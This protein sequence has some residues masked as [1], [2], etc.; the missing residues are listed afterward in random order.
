MITHTGFLH[1]FLFPSMIWSMPG[2]KVFLTFDDGPHPTVTPAVL[3]AL[4]RHGVT[5]TFFLSGQHLTGREAIVERIQREGHGIGIH[6]YH[7]NRKMAF[8]HRTT[9]EEIIR[10]KSLLHAITGTVPRLFRPPFG[11]FSWNTIRAAREHGVLLV[12][13]SC[14]TGDFSSMSDERVIRNALTGLQ[15]GSILVFHDNDLTEQRITR[16]LDAVIPEIKKRGFSFGAI[17]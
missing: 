10:S 16:L 15:R 9:S 12:M 5:A 7:H 11:F 3:D 6:A 13:W 1:R 8:S 4:A 2:P 14:L 17:R